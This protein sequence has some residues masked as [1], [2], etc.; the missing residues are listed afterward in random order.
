M[1]FFKSDNITFSI[2]NITLTITSGD[3]KISQNIKIETG[4]NNIFPALNEM[5]ADKNIHIILTI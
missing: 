1:K 4:E 2:D 3:K 5:V